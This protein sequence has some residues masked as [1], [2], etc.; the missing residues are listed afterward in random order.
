[1]VIRLLFIAIPLFA[2]QQDTLKLEYVIDITKI[3]VDSFFV[4]LSVDGIKSDSIT[5]QFPAIAPGSYSMIDAGRFVGNFKAF[6]DQDKELKIERKDV[7]QI[8]IYNS[9]AIKKITYEV[10]DTYDKQNSNKYVMS[11]SGSNIEPDNV[12]I[13]AQVVCGYFLD[14]QHNPIDIKFIYPKE[15]IIITALPKNGVIYYANDYD[16]LVDSPVMFGNL[17]IDKFNFDGVKIEIGCYSQSNMITASQIAEKLKPYIQAI[18]HLLGELPVDRYVFIYNFHKEMNDQWA[19]EHNYSSY[20]ALQEDSLNSLLDFI[21]YASTHEFCHIITPL[22]I[23]SDVI[24][25]FNFAIPNPSANIWFYEGFVEWMTRMAIVRE[26]LI[27]TEKFLDDLGSYYENYFHYFDTTMTLKQSS[28]SCYTNNFQWASSY[29]KGSMLAILIDIELLHQSNGNIGLIDVI[30]QLYKTYGDK[31]SF[32]DSTLIDIIGNFTSPKIKLMLENYVNT[33][34]TLPVA[35]YMERVGC[36]YYCELHTGKFKGYA[37]KWTFYR[38]EEVFVVRELDTKDSLVIRLGI[39]EG[40]KFR[41]LIFNGI[42]ILPLTPEWNQI[43]DSV[44]I[45]VP[46]TWIVDRDG[47]ELQ[48]SGVTRKEEVVE[49]NKIILMPD[50]TKEQIMLR[51]KWLNKH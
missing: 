14:Y 47:Q 46:F 50:P 41:Q 17:T 7:N 51:I 21:T 23:R 4:T 45:G 11:C 25:Q 42:E 30:K 31:N 15:W 26:G 6:D 39:K 20:H 38:E 29:Y 24:D 36:Q 44:E 28:L 2:S 18:L 43:R 35:E 27:S 22:H 9:S 8:V 13:N 16:H 34:A 1:M 10:D 32:V 12:V 19:L 40:D 33:T 48:L 49:T 3:E 5:F 37:R